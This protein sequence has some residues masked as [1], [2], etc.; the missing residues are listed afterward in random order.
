MSREPLT[1]EAVQGVHP[2]IRF[3]K[4]RRSL[5][6]A[7]ARASRVS[8]RSPRVFADAWKAEVIKENPVERVDMPEHTKIDER[9]RRILTDD[10][11]RT[12]L[13]GRASGPPGKKP[14]KDAETRL[15]EL[16]VLAVC[17]SSVACAP[18]S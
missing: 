9:Q 6:S 15:L 18:P 16:K 12:F 17:A 8:K 11:V 14:R 1:D 7:R 13:N 5:K 2:H 3:A 10:E 4:N